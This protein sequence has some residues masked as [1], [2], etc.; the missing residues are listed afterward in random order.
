MILGNKDK[1][2]VASTVA[3]PAFEG[4]HISCGMPAID[5]AIEEVKIKKTIDY[6]LSTIDFKVIG[7]KR[8]KGICGSG[9]IDACYQMLK[10]GIIDRSG[11]MRKGHKFKI[12]RNIFITQQDIRKLQ[13]AKAA[14][15]AATKT[16]IRRFKINDTEIEEILITGSF[17]NTIDKQSMV[18]IGLVPKIEKAR[19]G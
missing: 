1:I 19:I 13:L 12:C 18:G 17:G 14:I 15:Y 3:G 8:P 5:G 16:L 9:L 6:R 11:R 4:R 7:G 10:N 2:L